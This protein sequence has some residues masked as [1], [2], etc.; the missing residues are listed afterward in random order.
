[1]RLGGKSAN[2]TDEYAG[3]RHCL[4]EFDDGDQEHL[5][6][7]EIQLGILNLSSGGFIDVAHQ[8]ELPS[9]TLN[10]DIG[11]K[12]TLRD[13]SASDLA[14]ISVP[15]LPGMT[16]IIE[17]TDGCASQFQGQTNAGR[18]ARSA[19][20]AI[21]VRRQSVISQPGHGKNHSDHEGHT[22]DRN[23]KE[24]TLSSEAPVLC[25]SRSVVLTLAEFRRE[26]TQTHESK[27]S[28]WAPKDVVYAFYDE[29]L[30]EQTHPQF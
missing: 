27:H 18:V 22:M 5:S 20:S 3:P 7:R 11:R 17:D 4:V 1:V 14:A 29:K 12:W 19:P 30:L 9:G 15:V 6:W 26:P 8:Y 2:E 25:G 21:A 16:D 24:L 10:P 23:L 13:A 28:P